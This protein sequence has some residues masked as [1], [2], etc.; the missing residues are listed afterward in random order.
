MVR[1]IQKYIS[2]VFH[3]LFTLWFLGVMSDFVIKLHN[4]E[5][6]SVILFTVIQALS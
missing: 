3:L 4:H 5:S 6:E 1:N 2:V